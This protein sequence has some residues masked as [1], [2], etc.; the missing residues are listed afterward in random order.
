MMQGLLHMEGGE[1][2]LPFVRMFYSTPSTFLWEDEEGTVHVIP[3]GEGGDQ[4]DP[5]MPMLFALGQHSSLVTVS[6]RLHHGERL[7]AFL[8]D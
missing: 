4:G 7:C 6:D 1:K 5:L 2:L 3:Q 8:D